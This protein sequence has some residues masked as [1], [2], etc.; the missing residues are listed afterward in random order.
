MTTSTRRKV[1]RKR[2][3]SVR[4]PKHLKGMEHLV[5]VQLLRDAKVPDPQGEVKFALAADDP[6]KF[7]LDY[8][9]PDARLGVEVEGG[10][11]SGGAHGRGSG[12]LR[13]MEKQNVAVVLGW[14]ILR[15][16]P[17]HL[18]QPETIALIKRALSV[19][20]ATST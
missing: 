5:F 7:A 9:W 14:R 12:I 16:T 18:V 4:T 15:F 3:R 19:S 1:S 8:A 17:S 2:Q 11:W 6:R 13:D 20:P 10:I